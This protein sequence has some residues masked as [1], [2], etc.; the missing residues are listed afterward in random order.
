MTYR[1]VACF[2]NYFILNGDGFKLYSSVE[3]LEFHCPVHEQ[4]TCFWDS[5]VESCG[6]STLWFVK[7]E[8]E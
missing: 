4:C 6:S 8:M 5:K 3:K 1:K 2:C 7:G